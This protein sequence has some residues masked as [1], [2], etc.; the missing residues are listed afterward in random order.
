MTELLDETVPTTAQEELFRVS[1]NNFVNRAS[2]HRKVLAGSRFSPAPEDIDKW[3]DSKDLPELIWMSRIMDF[4]WSHR[5]N[6]S[7]NGDCN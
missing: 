5:C 3:I 7:C 4:I 2:N 6:F 1:V